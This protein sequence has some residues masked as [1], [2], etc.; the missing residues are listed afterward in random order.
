VTNHQG[1]LGMLQGTKEALI[2][3]QEQQKA[4]E[5]TSVAGG[6]IHLIENHEC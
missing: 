2:L 5:D 3:A 1:L 4:A 6:E